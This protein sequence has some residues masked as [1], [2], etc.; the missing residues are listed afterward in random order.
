MNIPEELRTI[1]MSMGMDEASIPQFLTTREGQI[2]MT[3]VRQSMNK[4]A[5]QDIANMKIRE[6][7]TN[8]LDPN[9]VIA[10]I[11]AVKGRIAEEK[12]KIPNKPVPHPLLR[13]SLLRTAAAERTAN[14]G[15]GAILGVLKTFSGIEKSYSNKD[16]KHLKRG[17]YF[18]MFS[19]W[20]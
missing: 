8:K 11:E 19:P 6:S 9:S 12:K 20:I 13:Q 18:S 17:M 3:Q 15:E 5:A 10:E 2:A 16:L 14:V 4:V 1:L 7:L